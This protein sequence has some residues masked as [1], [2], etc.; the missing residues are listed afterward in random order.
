MPRNTLHRYF[1]AGVNDKATE[2]PKRL[3]CKELASNTILQ[4]SLGLCGIS[5]FCGVVNEIL[6]SNDYWISCLITVLSLL[7]NEAE[8]SSKEPL[9]HFLISFS[10]E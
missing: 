10:L 2:L 1:S 7:R 5:V 8:T 3:N 6:P 4:P 9:L